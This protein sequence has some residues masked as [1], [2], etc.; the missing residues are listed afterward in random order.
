MQWKIGDRIPFYYSE[1]DGRIDAI[2]IGVA[3]SSSQST[4]V[5]VFLCCRCFSSGQETGSYIWYTDQEDACVSSTRRL[6]SIAES[7]KVLQENFP[8]MQFTVIR[9][10][11]GRKKGGR[12]S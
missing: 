2:A 9:Q 11:R 5:R 1:D 10:G 6:S 4:G 7:V 8:T 3:R 12:H